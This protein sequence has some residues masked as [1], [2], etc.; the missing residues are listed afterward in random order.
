M[1]NASCLEIC[2]DCESDVVI[3]QQLNSGQTD[4]Q[5]ASNTLTSTNQDKENPETLTNLENVGF[6]MYPNPVK[7][8]LNIKINT[9]ILT[10]GSVQIYSIN[11][12]LVQTHTLQK[13]GS[14]NLKLD[15]SQLKKGIYMVKIVNNKKDVFVK[16]IIKE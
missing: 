9:A 4:N 8:F 15:V 5:Q 1:N 7:E 2:E 6:Q 16:K 13:T 14:S 11:G 3:T 10:N 12:A